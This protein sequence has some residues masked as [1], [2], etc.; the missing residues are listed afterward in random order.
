MAF[1]RRS[2]Q[3]NEYDTTQN[4]NFENSSGEYELLEDGEE[5]EQIQSEPQQKCIHRFR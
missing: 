2:S 1:D 4:N 3:Q 5:H